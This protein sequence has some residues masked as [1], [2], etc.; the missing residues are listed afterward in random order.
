M[1]TKEFFIFK[2][3]YIMLFLVSCSSTVKNS[4]HLSLDQLISEKKIRIGTTE[5]YR[6][7]S[8]RDDN[9]HLIGIDI[10]LANNL[11]ASLGAT[12]EF[13]KTSW[14][15]LMKDFADHKFDIA[16]SGISKNLE[17]QKIALF[18][19]GYFKSGKTP[20]ARCSDKNK[21]SDLASID[22][23]TNRIIVNPGGTNF[24]FASQ[25]IKNAQIIT[26]DNNVKIFDEIKDGRADVMITDSVEADLQAFL[27]KNKLCRTMP[28][29][30]FD[31]SEKAILIQ[32]DLFTKE[33]I[34]AWLEQI[35]QDGTLKLII[36]RH[37]NF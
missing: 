2:I 8:Y 30:T 11:A 21:F 13:V 35:E 36:Q 6:P 24:K 1:I 32:R 33:F 15:N 9:G 31:T 19:K 14:P 29:K 10:D 26:F 28:N 16:I 17:R 18:S 25:N 20:I 7:F 12:V 37:T 4:N 5:D 22:K 34:N 27:N 3:V 23:K